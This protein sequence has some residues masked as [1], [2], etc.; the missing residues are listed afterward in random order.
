MTAGPSISL[1]VEAYNLHEGQS[2]AALRRALDA[3]FGLARTTDGACEVLLV[4][5]DVTAD[6]DALVARYAQLRRVLAPGAGYDALKD[7]GAQAARGDVVVYLDGD[8]VPDGPDWLDRLTQPIR[9]GEAL[10][11]CGTT[12]YEGG[13]IVAALSSV[14]DFGFVAEG[15]GGPVGCYT[16]NNVAFARALRVA[17]CPPTTPLR[18]ACY[19]HAQTLARR[20]QPVWHVPQALVWHEPPPFFKERL[21][22]GHDLV[23]VCWTDPLLREARWLRR[24]VWAAPLF[25]ADALRHDWRRA[26]RARGVPAL[27]GWRRMVV[28]ALIPLARLVDAVGIVGA[29]RAGPPVAVPQTPSSTF[30]K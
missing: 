15:T 19:A 29:L 28:M 7:A 20:G 17:V 8:C 24:G 2:L 10:A 5:P 13:G 11:T 4:Q 18:C 26:W 25:Y 14:L 21:R 30:L 16:S 12:L 3:A 1:I 23:G 6:L 27:H 22:R 9:R